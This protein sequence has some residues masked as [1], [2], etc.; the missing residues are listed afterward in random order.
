MSSNRQK[1]EDNLVSSL[2][3]VKKVNLVEYETR[4]ALYRDMRDGGDGG[5][6]RD[7][8][9][10]IRKLHFKKWKNSDFQ[11]LLER[12]GETPE[13]TEEEWLTRFAGEKKTFLGK[14][15]DFFT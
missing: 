7:S 13:L 5:P 12:L 4:V 9:T 15:F 2:E 1:Q 8:D 10:S 11:R 14:V 3:A 6:F